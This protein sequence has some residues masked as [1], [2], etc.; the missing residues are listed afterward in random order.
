MGEYPTEEQDNL[1]EHQQVPARVSRSGLVLFDPQ[2]TV[3][4]IV[5]LRSLEDWAASLGDY[6]ACRKA[7]EERLT[8]QREFVLWWDGQDKAQGGRGKTRNGSVM[9]LDDFGLSPMTVSR[10]RTRL[11]KDGQ[12]DDT[13]LINAM[14]DHLRKVIKTLD[15]EQAA[16]FSAESVEWYTPSVYIDAAREAMGGID[17]DPASCAKA[18]ETVK[19][20]EYWTASDQPS[21]LQRKWWGRVFLNP[22]YGKKDG[23]S[24][25]AMFCN[26]AIAEYQAGNLEAAVV[27]V[28]SVHSQRWQAPLYQYPVCFVNHRIQFVS[29]DGEENKNPT[30]QNVFIYL[31]RESDLFHQAFG[32]IGYVMVP[33]V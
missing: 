10:W 3:Q 23:D 20:E 25:A 28:N 2:K 12:P 7:V 19:A 4:E 14:A 31:G 21:P 22:P 1:G 30:F 29:G 33:Y 11:T 32:T 16:N 9:G 26:K 5:M 6:E 8:K 13:L 17:L 24:V 18:N 15:M 27:L